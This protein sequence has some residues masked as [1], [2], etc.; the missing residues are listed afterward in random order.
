MGVG[1]GFV[2]VVFLCLPELFSETCQFGVYYSTQMGISQ[3]I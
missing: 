1:G 2:V 3:T